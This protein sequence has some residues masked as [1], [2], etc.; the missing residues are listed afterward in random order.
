MQKVGMFGRA[1]SMAMASAMAMFGDLPGVL[2]GSRLDVSPMYK[3]ESL[4]ARDAARR[5]FL[6]SFAQT[7][8]Q[9]ARHTERARA[10]RERKA[11]RDLNNQGRREGSLV[12]RVPATFSPEARDRALAAHFGWEF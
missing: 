2:E 8:E 6:H 4:R 7:P 3:G 5:Q 1:A 12:F 10:K 11:I 9:A